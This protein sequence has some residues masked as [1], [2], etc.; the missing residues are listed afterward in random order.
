MESKVYHRG[1]HSPDDE[2]DLLLRHDAGYDND[3]PAFGLASEGGV[4]NTLRSAYSSFVTALL[5]IP[6]FV[7]C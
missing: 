1:G 5:Y 2:D 7:G 3:K 6:S 4:A